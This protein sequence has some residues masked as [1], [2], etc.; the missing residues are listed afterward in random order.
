M[1]IQP[2]IGDWQ[3]RQVNSYEWLPAKVPGG[4]HLDLLA[5]GRIP[6]PFVGDN[7][8]RV[9]WVAEADWEYR[10]RFNCST[11]LLMQKKILLVCDGLDTLATVRLNDHELGHTENMFR[12]YEWEVK[13]LLLS[14]DKNELTIS[15]A[16]SVK[17]ITQKQM[18]RGMMSPSHSI[19]G[20]PYL[21]KAPCQFGWDWGPKLPPIGIW[22]DIRLE[23]YNEA[24]FGEIHLRQ[25]HA[26]G[27]VSVVVRTAIEQWGKDPLSVKVCITAPDGKTMQKS[28]TFISGDGVTLDI[29][30]QNPQLW[31]PNGYGNQPLYGVEVSLHNPDNHG[32]EAC[33]RRTY[34][35]GLRTLELRQQED[36]W[37]RSFEFIVNGVRIFAKGSNWIPADS[38]PTR[39][40]SESL[41]FLIHSAADTHQ[42]M[43]RVWGGGFYE[44][45]RFYDLCDRYGILVW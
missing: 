20:G 34:Q 21:R 39:L 2:L 19:P 7:E 11:E 23:G 44:D 4:V 3:F 36:Q 1:H 22:K 9:A 12:R 32:G 40:T 33:D 35:L 16:S 18:I 37:G 25:K 10:L 43:L 5:N 17:F 41:E 38:F 45:E 29:P 27:Q 8:K 30:I 15:L 6:D 42:N 31:W 26:D 24:R 14:D 13:P 28:T